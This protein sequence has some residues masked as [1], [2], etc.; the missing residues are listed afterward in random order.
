MAACAFGI[1]VL[2]ASSAP[3]VIA[4]F[5]AVTRE[6]AALSAVEASEVVC[7]VDNVVGGLE[8]LKKANEVSIRVS[9]MFW[10]N[11]IP[12]GIGAKHPSGAS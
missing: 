3:T 8:V 11:Q 12:I 9:Y 10:I 7:A 4:W 6:V 1:V 5:F 2:H